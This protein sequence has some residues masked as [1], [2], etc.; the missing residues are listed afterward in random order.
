M[1][2]E[3]YTWRVFESHIGETAGARSSAACSSEREEEF[4]WLLGEAKSIIRELATEV[5]ERY[6][7]EKDEPPQLRKAREVIAE[8]DDMLGV[9]DAPR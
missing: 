6:V 4:V 3:E 8:I 5:G 1:N 2:D 7:I 9:E